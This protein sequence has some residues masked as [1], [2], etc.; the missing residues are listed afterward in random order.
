MNLARAVSRRWA[1]FTD[2]RQATFLDTGSGDPGQVRRFFEPPPFD[3]VAPFASQLKQITGHFLNHTFDLLG[4]GWVRIFHG[5]S[6]RGMCGQSFPPAPAREVDP[7]GTWLRSLINSSNVHEAQRIWRLVD[8]D[9]SPIDWQLDFKSGFRWSERSWFLDIRWGDFRGADIKVPWE[10][11]RMQHLTQ[12]A[13]AFGLATSGT[14]GFLPPV[15]YLREFRNQVLDF[16]ATNPPRYGVNWHCTMDVAIRVANWLVAYDLFR[17]YGG[18]LDLEFEEIFI[19][20]LYEHARHIVSHREWSSRF[21]NNH[22]IANIAGLLFVGAYLPSSPETDTWKAF[23]IQELIAEVDVQFN[24][25]GS[26]FEGSTCYHQLSAEMVAYCTAIVLA[27]GRTDGIPK[28]D[29]PTCIP[30]E[31]HLRSDPFAWFHNGHDGNQTVFP[32]GFVERLFRM[33]Q[34]SA[35]I[36]N[37]SGHVPQIGDNDSG[38]FLKIFPRYQEMT[39]KDARTRFGNLHDYTEFSDEDCYMWEVLLDY[40]GFID[41]ISALFCNPEW[42]RG[43]E[44]SPDAYVVTSLAKVRFDYSDTSFNSVLE[45]KGLQNGPGSPDISL[46]QQQQYEIALPAGA[47]IPHELRVAPYPG[48]GLYIWRTSRLFAAVRCGPVGQH[49]IGGHDHYD[50]LSLYLE[51]DGLVWLEDPGTFCYSPFPE[52]RHTYRSARSHWAPRPEISYAP[53]QSSSSL[54]HLEG[55][56]PGCVTEA[57]SGKFEGWVRSGEICLQR[58]IR[59]GFGKI[60]VRDSANVPLTRLDEVT[61]FTKCENLPCGVSPG[62]GWCL[63]R[64]R[65]DSQ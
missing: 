45:I 31:P 63:D 32:D 56:S 5:M 26:N 25:D 47:L 41:L 12:L 52:V 40:R 38:R 8:C 19:R 21:R 39:V 13:L 6:C 1:R 42:G 62:Y 7:D 18:R 22:Y 24:S 43:K 29:D 15:V 49:G 37:S 28:C 11:A 51:V 53:D 2:R 50:Q 14:I 55:A 59:F 36:T 20:S 27:L 10:L 65:F 44:S 46:P 57:S 58:T 23:A 64:V 4:S 48:L 61:K 35:D 17:S 30:G 16:I 34:F 9:Y 60:Q 33:G 3:I 54:F